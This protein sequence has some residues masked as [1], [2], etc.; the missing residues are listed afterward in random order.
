MRGIEMT[1]KDT[2]KREYREINEERE[3]AQKR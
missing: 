1:R 2:E 3:W